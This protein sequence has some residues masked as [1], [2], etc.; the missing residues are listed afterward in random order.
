MFDTHAHLN[1]QDF[2]KDRNDII[3]ECRNKE[4][5]IIN[6][7][8]TLET[9]IKAVEIA[10]K[11]SRVYASVGIH[12]LHAEEEFDFDKLE[13]IVENKNVVAIGETGLD[14]KKKKTIKKQEELF[15]KHI[16]LAKRKKLPLILHSRKAHEKTLKMIP[17]WQGVVHCFTGNLKQAERYIKKGYFIGING[18]IFKMNLKKVIKRIPLKNILIETDC[19][20]LSSPEW[21]GKNTPLGVIP[22]IGKIA[23]IKNENVEKVVKITDENAKSLFS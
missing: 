7:G 4:I 10:K 6:V 18:I 19:P 8:S 22:V 16:D 12:P 5:N 13:D 14:N 23:E 2:D 20:Y 21:K 9:S 11:N 3:R 17:K 1:F 15:L